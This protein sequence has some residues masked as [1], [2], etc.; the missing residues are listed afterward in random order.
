MLAK[1][2]WGGQVESVLAGTPAIAVRVAGEM[3]SRP[4]GINNG[5]DVPAAWL[6]AAAQRG[7]VLFLP[8]HPAV[9]KPTGSPPWASS[10]PTDPSDDDA[11][12]DRLLTLAR[13][14]Q[15]AGG[16]ATI[17]TDPHPH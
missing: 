12:V 13:A 8:P 11:F 2:P 15:L 4:A 17:T 10:Q 1:T 6:G 16:L 7:S 5:L 3:Q 14:H 9:W